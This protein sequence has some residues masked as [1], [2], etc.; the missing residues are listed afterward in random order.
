MKNFKKGFT[1]I[2]LL[3]VVAIIGILASVVLASLNSAR[4]K[5]KDA[6]AMSSFSQARAG[7]EIAYSNLGNTYAAMCPTITTGAVSATDATNAVE[8]SQALRNAQKTLGTVTALTDV[9]GVTCGSDA[10]TY[11]ASIKLNAANSY[12]CVDSTGFAGVKTSAQTAG[13]K[14]CS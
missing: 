9:G 12:Y 5:G 6:A 4:T 1:L 3:V 11:A 2:E 14:V 7:A 10:T 13:A 8:F